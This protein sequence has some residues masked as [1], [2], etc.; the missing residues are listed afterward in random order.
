MPEVE[1]RLYWSYSYRAYVL[2]QLQYRG[3]IAKATALA[4]FD[5]CY[6]TSL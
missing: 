1:M 5:F 3:S 6:R 4:R 2:A